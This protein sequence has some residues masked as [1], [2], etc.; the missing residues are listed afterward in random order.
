MIRC[1]TALNLVELLVVV[2]VIV[3]LAALLLPGLARARHL[4]LRAVCQSNLRQYGVVCASYANDSDGW[5]FEAYQGTPYRVAV[6]PATLFSPPHVDLRPILL[7]YG[8]TSHLYFCPSSGGRL[9]LPREF[10]SYSPGG[11]TQYN[12]GYMNLAGLRG[13]NV[14]AYRLADQTA[15]TYPSSK[16]AGEQPNAPLGA[17]KAVAYP[18]AGCGTAVEPFP[19]WSNHLWSE[20]VEGANSIHA[21]GHAKWTP[22]DRWTRQ[23]FRNHSGNWNGW[24]WW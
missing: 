1:N 8:G 14:A 2:A 12:M 13:T 16:R 5:Y 20:Q 22:R 3:V 23:V 24:Y 6:V 21:D 18:A 15:L 7:D 10:G 11:F 17:D 4:A 9:P 19:L